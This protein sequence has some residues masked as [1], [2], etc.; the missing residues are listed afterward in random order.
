MGCISSTK[1][2]V[3]TPGTAITQYAAVAYNTQTWKDTKPHLWSTFGSLGTFLLDTVT[4]TGISCSSIS[5]NSPL[6]RHRGGPIM[7]PWSNKNC[8]VSTK[9][10]F[11]LHADARG[12]PGVWL[13][14]SSPD[15]LPAE[16]AATLSACCLPAS[17]SA[18][19]VLSRQRGGSSSCS[20]LPQLCKKSLKM[21]QPQNKSSLC[22]IRE[23]RCQITEDESKLNLS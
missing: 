14:E 16:A 6:R 7:P 23:M 13:A 3:K 22:A 17:P 15:T 18:Q 1:N 21:T 5:C 8:S 19:G 11:I 4:Q 10:G 2:T 12:F 9:Q 20:V